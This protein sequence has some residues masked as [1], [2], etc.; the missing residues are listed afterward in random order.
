MRLFTLL[1]GERV[2][3]INSWLISVILRMKGVKVGKNLFIKG[4]PRLIINGRGGNI[5][6]G[7]NVRIM[8]DIDL[9]NRED[10]IIDIGDGVMIDE[11]C[12]LVAANKAILK[13][14]TGSRIGPFT[15]FN[16]GEDVSVGK[17]VLISGFCYIQSSN[18]GIKKGS[19]I[20]TQTHTY[21]QIGIGDY[22]WIGS[23]VTVLPSVAIGEGAV[24]GAKAVVTKDIES[25]AIAV[26][27]PARKIGMRE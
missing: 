22:A 9:R 18:H 6:I 4:V 11:N 15:I 14:M 3:L 25:N 19:P 7:N 12:R 21:G 23:H 24:V 8:G 13:I 5:R 20:I 26:G 10:G 17:N 16:C 1:F 2:F 27:V